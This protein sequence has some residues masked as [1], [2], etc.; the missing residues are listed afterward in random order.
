MSKQTNKVMRT[1]FL[2]LREFKDYHP[3]DEFFTSNEEAK[4]IEEHFE[5][6][7]RTAL[8]LQ[9]LRDM[10]VL[11][12]NWCNKMNPDKQDDNFSAMLSITS[13]IDMHIYKVGTN[14]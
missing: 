1:N 8:D 10:V 7:G 2:M 9:N 4:K 6:E 12:Y 3:A 5:L 13:V 14:K 11:W